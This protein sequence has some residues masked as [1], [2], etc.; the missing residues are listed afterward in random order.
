[1]LV[2]VKKRI[3]TTDKGP[4]NYTRVDGRTKISILDL[5]TTLFC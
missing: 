5:A 1:M 3:R 4:D 2:R